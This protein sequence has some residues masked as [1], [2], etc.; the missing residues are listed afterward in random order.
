[1]FLKSANC[2]RSFFRLGMTGEREIVLVMEVSR[3]Y[4]VPTLEERLD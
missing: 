4:R 2:L 1:M 3:K